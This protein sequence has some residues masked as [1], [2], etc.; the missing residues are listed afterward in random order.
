EQNIDTALKA[1]FTPIAKQLAENETIII[2][3]LNQIQ[4]SPVNIGGYYEPNET[5][6]TNAMRPSKT[7]N[8]I[9]G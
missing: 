9:L 7:L 8:S 5:L 3:E 4:G 1:E 2:T 6:V